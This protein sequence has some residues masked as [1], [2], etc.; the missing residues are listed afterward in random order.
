MAVNLEKLSQAV[1]AL[2]RMGA[3]RVILFGSALESCETA[4]D[5]DLGAEG[6]PLD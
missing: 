2:V 3:R 1:D 5:I 4:N 6:I